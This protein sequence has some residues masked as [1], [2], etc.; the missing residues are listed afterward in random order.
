MI[1]RVPPAYRPLIAEAYRRLPVG[2]AQRVSHV[3]FVCGVDPVFV[4]L[5]RYED[6]RAVQHCVY[7]YLLDR[8]AV[9]RRTTICLP[10][11]SDDP[12]DVVHELGHALHEVVRW[13]L[14]AAPVSE[15]ARTDRYEAFAEALVAHTH[16]YGDQDVLASDLA[17]L[18][19]FD[20][21]AA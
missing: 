8:P 11:H 14:D 21:L 10:F 12:A 20:E 6:C 16:F 2:I 13:E 3:Q 19:L 9:D 7:G 5:H 15:Y 17:T 1:E 18:A 4:G